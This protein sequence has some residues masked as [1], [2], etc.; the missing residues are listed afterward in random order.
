MIKRIG[1]PIANELLIGPHSRGQ[2][3]DCNIP[4]LGFSTAKRVGDEVSPLGV[5]H[6]DGGKE[7]KSYNVERSGDAVR[8]EEGDFYK[9][10]WGFQPSKGLGMKFPHWGFF[11]PMEE[12]KRKVITLTGLSTLSGLKKVIFNKRFWGFQ[13]PKG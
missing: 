4:L 6:P 2:P 7:K 1:M 5:F 3:E 9:R 8:F 11:T 13:P 10:F 12:M